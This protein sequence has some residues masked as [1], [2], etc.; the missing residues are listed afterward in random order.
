MIYDINFKK[1]IIQMHLEF[2]KNSNLKIKNFF[3]II[4]KCFNIGKS[5]IYEWINNSDINNKEPIITDY[6]N[7]K[8]TPIIELFIIN[9]SK[10]NSIKKFKKIIF[11]NF[12]I[13]LNKNEIACILEKNKIKTKK[14]K[15]DI[16]IKKSKPVIII[17]SEHEQFII[18]NQTLS[19][20]DIT[21]IINKNFNINFCDK[22]IV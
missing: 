16:L 5:T 17:T 20:K 18:E 4:K 9:N 13:K 22:N 21:K 11:D 7:D 6:K 2:N 1:S 15:N 14:F 12:N 8:I 3:D 19:I 10:I